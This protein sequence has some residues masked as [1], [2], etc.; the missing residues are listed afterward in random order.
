MKY[1]IVSTTTYLL[2]V[3][4]ESRQV[5]PLEHARPEYYGISWFANTQDLVTSHSGLNNGDLVDI[6]SYAQSEKGWLSSGEMS[7]RPILSA[8]HQIVCAP[9]GRVICTNTGRNTITVLDLKQPTVFQEAGISDARWDR[10]ALDNVTG[11]HLN[12]VFLRSDH[13]YVIAHGHSFGSKL[14]TFHYPSL[15]LISIDPLGSR[16]G[17]HNIWVTA[18]DQRI[19]C[20]SENGRLIDLD[21]S[22]PLWESGAAIYT[23]GLAASAEYVLIGESQRASRNARR[24]TSTGL[25]ILD[26]STWTSIDYLCL[27]PYGP[28]HEVRLLDVPDDAHHGHI[29]NGIDLLLKQDARR[30]L[31]EQ[32]LKTASFAS[33]ANNIWSGYEPLFGSPT[34]LPDGAKRAAPDQFCLVIKQNQVEPKLAFAYTLEH[35]SGAHVSAVLGYR[36]NGGDRC[37]IA[38]LLQPTGVSSTLTVWR[39]DGLVWVSLPDMNIHNL[40][41]FGTMQLA[42]TEHRAT[43]SIN[44]EEI[45]TVSAETLGVERCDQGVGI[46]WAGASVRPVEAGCC[47]P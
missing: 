17:L 31:S 30:Q 24:H 3:D 42:T 33:E 11:D 41:G 13:L 47:A 46:R 5:Q 4:L 21:C 14:V 10:L 23:R 36:G 28:V 2:L 1:A 26:R 34:P 44:N 38:L 7:S 43:L 8:P 32:R 16:T 45:I 20:D 27:G 39:N 9:D 35:Q 37:M 29:F 40:P 19:S 6:S 15:E 25:W 18:D 22:I 12:S